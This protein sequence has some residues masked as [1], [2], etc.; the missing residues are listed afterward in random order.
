MP[1]LVDDV[2][3]FSKDFG[4]EEGHQFDQQAA[5]L[6]FFLHLLDE[7]RFFTVPQQAVSL[8]CLVDVRELAFGV[9]TGV[10]VEFLVVEAHLVVDLAVD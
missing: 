4:V 8:Y 1:D 9:V 5:E 3:N 10:L 2:K 6:G 7:L